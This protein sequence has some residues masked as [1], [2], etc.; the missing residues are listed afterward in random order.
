MKVR[1][2]SQAEQGQNE[3]WEFNVVKVI[4]WLDYEQVCELV[5][6]LFKDLHCSS[7]VVHWVWLADVD[8]HGVYIIWE[9]YSL[10]ACVSFSLYKVS[11]SCYSDLDVC[12]LVW[13]SLVISLIKLWMI[14]ITHLHCMSC[15]HVLC[16][17]AYLSKNHCFS[18]EWPCDIQNIIFAGDLNISWQILRFV[19]DSEVCVSYDKINYMLCKHLI[20]H[21]SFKALFD[22]FSL[23]VRLF[24]V[25]NAV[26]HSQN[27]DI[28]FWLYWECFW[29]IFSHCWWKIE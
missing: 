19:S 1:G 22:A 3:C 6:I 29:C 15:A 18:D 28:L 11:L 12:N 17:K 24:I 26:W 23:L 9:F 21:H 4:V 2:W 13:S 16:L 20:L 7:S 10:R 27:W 5:L 8:I 14:I 25:N